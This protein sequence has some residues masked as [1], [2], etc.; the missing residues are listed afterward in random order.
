MEDKK[1]VLNNSE[2]TA[3]IKSVYDTVKSYDGFTDI[4]VNFEDLNTDGAPCIGI[5]TMPGA[6]Y[7]KKYI[8]GG[9]EALLPFSIVYRASVNVD[10]QKFQIIECLNKLGEWFIENLPVLDDGRVTEKVEQT[11]VPYRNMIDP[12][13]ENDYIVTFQMTYRKDE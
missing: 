3:V 9:F 6:I 8:T 2:C 13:C 11:S 12:G 5:F 7:L 4:V 1:E 10:S